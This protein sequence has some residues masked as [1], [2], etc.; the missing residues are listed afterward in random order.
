MDVVYDSGAGRGSATGADAIATAADAARGSKK[1]KTKGTSTSRKTKSKTQKGQG[2]NKNKHEEEEQSKSIEK[3]ADSSSSTTIRKWDGADSSTIRKWESDAADG[4]PG[5]GVVNVKVSDNAN[6][7][8]SGGA[9]NKSGGANDVIS[10]LQ[11][12]LDDVGKMNV[13]AN[14]A[15]K[16]DGVVR[17][18]DS[19][20]A[21]ASADSAVYE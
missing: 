2:G 12:G 13:E 3:V 11:P 18:G 9:I 16:I 8:T 15:T 4:T 20:E 6:C 5:T 10:S 21:T 1:K 19:A 17:V 14:E 7:T